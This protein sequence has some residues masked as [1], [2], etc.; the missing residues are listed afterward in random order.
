VTD[1]SDEIIVHPAP[2]PK[3][4]TWRLIVLALVLVALVV[5]GKVTGVTD[6]L[7][8]PAIRS[9]MNEL[10][11]LG[12][13]LYLVVF[14]VGELMQVPGMVFMLAA[15]VA[16]GSLW[17]GIA[18]FVGGILSVC[19]TFGLVRRVGGQPLGEI[20]WPIMRK[21]LELLGERPIA[22]VAVLRL[23][24]TLSPVLNYALAMSSVRFRDYVI[25]SVLGFLPW[26]IGVAVATEKVLEYTGIAH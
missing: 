17:G 5:V 18:A 8:V 10:G 25:G 11:V 23:L 19:F 16:Y 12:F 9:F 24:F 22:V 20:K 6:Q 13:V 4:K 1:S 3:K 14:C 7:T 26:A 2:A 21:V 15:A